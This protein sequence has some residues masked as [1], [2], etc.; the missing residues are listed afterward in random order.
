MTFDI[1][2]E[3]EHV[4]VFSQNLLL[5]SFFDNWIYNERILPQNSFITA[6][7]LSG[8]NRDQQF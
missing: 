4:S 2:I 5:R 3:V 6:D 8:V 7:G 1:G